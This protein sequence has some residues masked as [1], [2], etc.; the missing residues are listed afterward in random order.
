MIRVG[1]SGWSYRE[2]RG[3]FYPQ[4]LPAREA[5]AFASRHFAT[6]E[7][8]ATFY[9]PQPRERFIRWREATP[10]GFVFAV[11]A[12]RQITHLRRLANA[13]APLSAFFAGGVLALGDKLGPI[14]WQL[15]RSLAFDETVFEEFLALLPRDTAAAARLAGLPPA[16]ER[17][18]RHAIEVRHDSFH[19]PRFLALLHRHTA[20]LV[21]TDAADSPASVEGE[22]AYLRLHGTGTRYTGAYDGAALDRWAARIRAWDAAGHDVFA[23]FNNT[24]KGD[25]PY[26]AQALIR[27]LDTAQSR[28]GQMASSW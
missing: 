17:P 8:N 5:L 18:L 22:I 6:I 11:K 14:L 19:A 9:G 23:Y 12:P 16:P 20:S 25:A 27:R 15:P 26:D 28:A 4:D 24:I 1:I 3:G 7:I 2:W 21:I 10:Q 13:D